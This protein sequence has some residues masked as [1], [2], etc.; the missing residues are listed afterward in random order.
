MRLSKK[1]LFWGLGVLVIVLAIVLF[2]VFKKV[3]PEVY[4]PDTVYQTGYE[5]LEWN[6]NSEGHKW[7]IADTADFIVSGGDETGIKFWEGKIDPLKVV[8]GMTQTMRI[9]VS[10]PNGLAS[11]TAEI[12]TDNGIN[13]VELK[14]TGVL[15]ARDLNDRHGVYVI[16]ENGV[17]A[18]NSPEEARAWRLALVKEEESRG[19][20]S[21]AMASSGER[22]LGRFLGG[23]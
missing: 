3:V 16:E 11:V 14:K 1:A 4:A 13:S 23:L 2:F 12:E 17:L 18:I 9:V 7:A 5:H 20:V 15:A 8:P 6:V 21:G 19:L 22:G 10:S